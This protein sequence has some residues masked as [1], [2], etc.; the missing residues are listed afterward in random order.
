MLLERC[1][2]QPKPDF[3]ITEGSVSPFWILTQIQFVVGQ[4]GPAV[5]LDQLPER[6]LRLY[7]PLDV[8]AVGTYFDQNSLSA[9]EG[10][11]VSP[12]GSRDFQL[13]SFGGRLMPSRRSGFDSTPI[14]KAASS[15]V[16]VMGPTTRPT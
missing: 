16:R 14:I 15:T 7:Q 2:F 1:S 6:G 8:F 9:G 13:M 3:T 11:V 5:F 4:F 12:F 10:P